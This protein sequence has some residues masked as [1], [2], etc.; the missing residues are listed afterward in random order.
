[1]ATLSPGL[2]IERPRRIVLTIPFLPMVKGA[3]ACDQFWRPGCWSQQALGASLQPTTLSSANGAS[4]AFAALPA[5]R[6]RRP[7][8]KTAFEVA[9]DG[10]VSSTVGCN[11][12]IGKPSLE[13]DRLR[14]GPMAAARMAC[15]SPLDRL[16]TAYMAALDAVRSYRVEE[17]RLTLVDEAGRAAVVLVRSE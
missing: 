8:S 4:S 12:I 14:F 17:T 13:G 7:H 10:R 16:E 15:P 5:S 3:A 6:P 1:V 9:A 11:R 2:S